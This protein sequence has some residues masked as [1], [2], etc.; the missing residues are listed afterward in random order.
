MMNEA[1]ASSGFLAFFRGPS[2]ITL[3]PKQLAP[4]LPVEV[5]P[6]RDICGE[7]TEAV[8]K[9]GLKMGFYYSLPEW[10]SD[11]HRWY[12]DPDENIGTYV[13]THMIPQFKELGAM[14]TC[15]S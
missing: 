9:K 8:R 1:V 10:K 6:H 14:P 15:V 12:V 11:I 7:L 13:D 2:T 5:G 3:A 4:I